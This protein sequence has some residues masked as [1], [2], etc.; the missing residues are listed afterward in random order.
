MVSVISTSSPSPQSSIDALSILRFSYTVF[1][2]YRSPMPIVNFHLFAIGI[3]FRTFYI[4]K[5]L[6]I[7]L[8]FNRFILLFFKII[9]DNLRCVR[10]PSIIPLIPINRSRWHIDS[11]HTKRITTR[12]IWWSS[13]LAIYTCQ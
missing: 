4:I 1:F 3:Y 10:F 2:A 11:L 5:N 8:K 6:L 13:C 12:T 7:Y 9:S